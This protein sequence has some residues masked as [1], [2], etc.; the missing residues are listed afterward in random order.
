MSLTNKQEQGLKIA[1]KRFNSGERYTCISGY[2]G[3]GKSF[4]VRAIIEALDIPED[5]ICFSCFTGKAAQVLQ[6]MGNKNVMTLHKLLFD[7]KP[8]PNGQFIHIPKPIIDYTLVIADECSMIPR[9]L[10]NLLFSH[11]EA[12]IICL[13]DPF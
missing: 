7:S 9:S 6:K 5:E 2:A 8:L 13:G 1:V 4:L 10:M 3:V 11:K 12:H